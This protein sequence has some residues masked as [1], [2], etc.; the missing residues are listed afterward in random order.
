MESTNAAELSLTPVLKTTGQLM[1]YLMQ[2]PFLN[3]YPCPRLGD[4]IS[5]TKG[6]LK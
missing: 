5:V 3:S 6:Y 2:D 4:M 1:N